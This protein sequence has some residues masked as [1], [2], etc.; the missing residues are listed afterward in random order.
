M[1]RSGF[2]GP[3]HV[4]AYFKNVIAYL[5]LTYTVRVLLCATFWTPR[6]DTGGA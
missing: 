2:I 6:E 3:R 1:G 5:I 4:K